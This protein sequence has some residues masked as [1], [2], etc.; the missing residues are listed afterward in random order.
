MNGNSFEVRGTL[1]IKD[2]CCVPIGI[3][4]TRY[5]QRGIDPKR[6]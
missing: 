4:L 5:A 2:Y 6:V 1:I 3:R